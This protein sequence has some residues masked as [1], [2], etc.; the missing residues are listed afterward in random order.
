MEYL[1][2]CFY[3]SH[4]GES[5][6]PVG[7]TIFAML[8]SIIWADKQ[9]DQA[10]KMK[11]CIFTYSHRRK[12]NFKKQKK[13]MNVAREERRCR[14]KHI[15]DECVYFSALYLNQNELYSVHSLHLKQSYVSFAMER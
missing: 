1:A 14:K 3:Y 12:I 15:L 7:A 13:E 2:V 5:G 11:M 4:F 8:Q 10:I 9:N 6:N